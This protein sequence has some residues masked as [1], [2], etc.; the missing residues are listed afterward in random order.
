MDEGMLSRWL[1]GS[2]PPTAALLTKSRPFV[3][4][5]A[6]HRLRAVLKELDVLGGPA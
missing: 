6:A 4:S 3:A 1:L 5:A 2:W